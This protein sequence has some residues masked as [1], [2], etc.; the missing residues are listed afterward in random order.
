MSRVQ[1]KKQRTNCSVS[2]F[3][4]LQSG[5]RPSFV[6]GRPSSVVMYIV[7]EVLCV[8]PISSCTGVS[9]IFPLVPF[10]FPLLIFLCNFQIFPCIFTVVQ[11]IFP[12]SMCIFTMVLCIFPEFHCIFPVIP[13]ILQ[14]VCVYFQ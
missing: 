1:K 3:R 2:Y 6:D 11:I 14:V 5:I 13:C 4:H 7:Q 10:I 8:F 9:W 12:V